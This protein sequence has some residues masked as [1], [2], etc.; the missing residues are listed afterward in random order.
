MR[1]SNF[2]CIVTGLISNFLWSLIQYIIPIISV[3]TGVLLLFK[4]FAAA[5]IAV[6]FMAV[7]IKFY[8]REAIV[9]K[10]N[11]YEL[12]IDEIGENAA[13]T[14]TVQA[15]INHDGIR[16]L[17][18]DCEL[19]D[20]WTNVGITNDFDATPF[21][22]DINN[23]GHYIIV[24]DKHFQKHKTHE[25]IVKTEFKKDKEDLKTCNFV[26]IKLKTH[27]ITQ[28]VKIPEKAQL[29]GDV[30]FVAR[31]ASGCVVYEDA[32]TAFKSHKANGKNVKNELMIDD[33]I[34]YNVY[35]RVVRW[36]KRNYHYAIEFKLSK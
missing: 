18:G 10:D 13:Y 26:T 34:S 9:Y 31:K 3:I 33:R 23:P 25:Y 30:K 17:I 1:D 16:A 35:K 21:P 20:G 4:L 6:V 19:R 28:I 36:P 15:I 12:I 27:S 29:E 14:R 7:L 5:V 22:Y 8:P 32:L 24:S 11:K 2:K